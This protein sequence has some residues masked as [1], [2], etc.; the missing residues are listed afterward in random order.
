[1]I[2][3]RGLC[4]CTWHTRPRMNAPCRTRRQLA[5][6]PPG[7][8]YR[9]KVSHCSGVSPFT[10]A[11]ICESFTATRAFI[12]TSVFLSCQQCTSEEMRAGGFPGK[13]R[14]RVHPCTTAA[15]Q[16]TPHSTKHNDC[17]MLRASYLDG[18]LLGTHGRIV[19]CRADSSGE[20]ACCESSINGGIALLYRRKARCIIFSHL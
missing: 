5:A 20:V 18:D 4:R 3:F 14:G 11:E 9:I 19:Q 16:C 17:D 10:T 7:H 6:H 2:A 13:P 8:T 15:L 1:M 12:T